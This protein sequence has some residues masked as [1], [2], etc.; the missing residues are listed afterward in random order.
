MLS[1]EH[2]QQLAEPPTGALSQAMD[3]LGMVG[4]MAGSVPHSTQVPHRMVGSARTVSQGARHIGAESDRA[5]TRHPALVVVIPPQVIEAASKIV[6][7]E[8]ELAE[9]LTLAGGSLTA[10]GA[11]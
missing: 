8:R 4:T 11:N 9:R 1:E 5:Y 7:H 10:A 3:A 2:R 6:A